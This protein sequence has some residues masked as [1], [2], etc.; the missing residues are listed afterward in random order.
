MNTD[1]AFTVPVL[2]SVLP[3][4]L[5]VC[6]LNVSMIMVVKFQLGFCVVYREG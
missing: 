1:E 2:F 4:I 5:L 3:G 6:L